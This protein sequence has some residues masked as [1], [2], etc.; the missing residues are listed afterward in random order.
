MLLFGLGVLT[1]DQAAQWAQLAVSLITLLFAFLYATT[2]WRTALYAITGPL[3]SI[4][5]AYGIVSDV[6]W[7]VIAA[8]VGYALGITTAA[9]KTVQ[10]GVPDLAGQHRRAA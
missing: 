5:M 3:G 2:P 1:S 10:P 8:S 4:L 6:R 9:A 7:A